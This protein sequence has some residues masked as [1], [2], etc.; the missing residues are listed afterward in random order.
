MIPDEIT[1][2]LVERAHVGI[3]GTRNADMVPRA[4]YVS[5]WVV[6]ADR[7]TINCSIAES[8]TAN[9]V[10]NLEDN[11][12]IAMTIEQLGSHETY[13][14]K[15]RF[16]DVHQP[17]DKDLAAVEQIRERFTE[18]MSPRVG[19]DGELCGH[20]IAHPGIVVRF[21]VSE[22]FLQTPGPGAGKRL[23]PK[24]ETS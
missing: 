5:G 18:F 16:I 1:E 6:E 20:Y 22:I 2:F 21:S 11:Q 14:F 9:L 10:R 24:E 8:H 19:G 17:D 15:G 3:C 7:E 23:V 12:Q 4:H 13:Q